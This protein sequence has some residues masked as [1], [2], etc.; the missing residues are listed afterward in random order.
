MPVSDY[1]IST[2]FLIFLMLF[3]LIGNSPALHRWLD[4]VTGMARREGEAAPEKAPGE[5]APGGMSRQVKDYEAIIFLQL[6]LAGDKGLSPTG[7][8]D[9]LHFDG[10]KGSRLHGSPGVGPAGR[11][12]R[13]K[14][15][16][17]GKRAGARRSGGDHSP[18]S[19]RRGEVAP[20]LGTTGI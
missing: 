1:A 5:E 11:S 20:L 7:L 17:V 8:S 15:P 12:P 4:R 13:Q 18:S 3:L 14:I 19:H 6:A 2:L 10:R 9:N 16:S